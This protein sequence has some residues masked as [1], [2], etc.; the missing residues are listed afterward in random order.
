MEQ[1]RQLKAMSNPL[2]LEVIRSRA[3]YQNVR[4]VKILRPIKAPRRIGVAC[5]GGD[6]RL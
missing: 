3:L 4:P 2:L 1:Q 5:S 6:C